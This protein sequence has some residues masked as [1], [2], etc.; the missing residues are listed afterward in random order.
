MNRFGH[1]PLWLIANL[2]YERGANYC[3]PT[4]RAPCAVSKTLLRKNRHG[5]ERTTIHHQLSC[6]QGVRTA[7]PRKG[8]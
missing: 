1:A 7:S 5:Q 2:V 8:T 4:V 6:T 3:R